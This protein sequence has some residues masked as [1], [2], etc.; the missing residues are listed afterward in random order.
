MP[1]PASWPGWRPPA[2]RSP[3]PCPVVCD[4]RGCQ[5]SEL[6]ICLPRNPEYQPRPMSRPPGQR[7]AAAAPARIARVAAPHPVRARPARRR[8][9]DHPDMPRAT[10]HPGST[11][12]P[13]ITDPARVEHRDLVMER[14]GQRVASDPICRRFDPLGSAGSGGGRRSRVYRARP[15]GAGA[16]CPCRGEPA[17][18]PRG[19]SPG[20]FPRRR[21]AGPAA[22]DIRQPPC[23]AAASPGGRAEG[24]SR[25]CRRRGRWRPTPA[26]GPVRSTGSRA[27][28]GTRAR[29]GRIASRAARISRPTCCADRIASTETRMPRSRYHARTADVT[30]R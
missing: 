15:G 5:I 17:V 20:R 12:Q 30:A 22:A 13:S 23:Q 16:G 25:M 9:A 27:C 14:D 6:R 28:S 21:R 11:A 7:R 4:P 19:V 18:K 10:V 26:P 1:L 29:N 8:P 2:G 3:R 24:L